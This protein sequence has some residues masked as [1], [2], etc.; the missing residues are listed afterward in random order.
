MI[1]DLHLFG[2]PLNI[3]YS[4]T[5]IAPTFRLYDTA[6]TPPS[7]CPCLRYSLKTR[8]ARLL[9]LHSTG[10]ALR[11]RMHARVLV[12]YRETQSAADRVSVVG[13][14]KDLEIAS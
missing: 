14:S 1:L 10:P 8:A 13:G 4:I 5:K 11:P 2:P 12:M 6:L 7:G 3:L 9:L